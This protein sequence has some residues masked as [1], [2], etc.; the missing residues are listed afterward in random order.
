MDTFGGLLN[1]T[2]MLNCSGLPPN[3]S[4]KRT[5]TT[6]PLSHTN[7]DSPHDDNF[8]ASGET[9]YNLLLSDLQEVPLLQSNR[10]LCFL[11]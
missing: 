1:A 3:G 10:F 7:A 9:L 4:T 6:P 5:G 2:V 8:L 11:R